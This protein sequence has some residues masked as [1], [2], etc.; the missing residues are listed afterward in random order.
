[1]CKNTHRYFGVNFLKKTL[2]KERR[3][4]IFSIYLKIKKIKQKNYS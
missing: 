1:M 3:E 4:Y 2:K